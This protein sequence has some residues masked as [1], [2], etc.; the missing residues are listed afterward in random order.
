MYFEFKKKSIIVSDF[1]PAKINITKKIL[2][3]TASPYIL[4]GVKP[5]SKYK[6]SLKFFSED[7]LFTNESSKEI[8]MPQGGNILKGR[9]FNIHLKLKDNMFQN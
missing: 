9:F 7:E 3:P 4:H 1:D 2:Y 8:E 6:V 5:W